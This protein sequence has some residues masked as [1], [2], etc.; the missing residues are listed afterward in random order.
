[1]L[2]PVIRMSIRWRARAGRN[3]LNFRV[4]LNAKLAIPI[5]M[6]S[7]C[8]GKPTQ[9]AYDVVDILFTRTDRQLAKLEDIVA[10]DVASC[11]D[12]VRRARTAPVIE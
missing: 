6:I 8:E 1:M 12:L 2:Q 9:Q 4:K 11:N 10:K 5:G 3:M 7:G